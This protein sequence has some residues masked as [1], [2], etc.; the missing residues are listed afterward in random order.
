MQTHAETIVGLV[1][2]MSQRSPFECF[3]KGPDRAVMIRG[4]KQRLGMD[5]DGNLP[6][7]MREAVQHV[8]KLIIDSI[9][10][11]GTAK[12]DQ[13]QYFSNGILA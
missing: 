8:T 3:Q 4:L 12:Y 13:F 9:D 6:A 5:D 2:T 11:F 10:H 1:E 7:T